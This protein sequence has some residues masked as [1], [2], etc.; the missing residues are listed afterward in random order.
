MEPVFTLL[1][2]LA[3]RLGGP[4]YCG[5]KAERLNRNVAGWAIIGLFFPIISMIVISCL[6]PLT[7]WHS[8]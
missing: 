1:L 7:N 6:N 2:I 3:L 4:I 5:L 8:D